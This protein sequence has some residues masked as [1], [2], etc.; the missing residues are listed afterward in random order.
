MSSAAPADAAATFAAALES[1]AYFEDPA[2]AWTAAR[3]AGAMVKLPFG[4]GVW[5]CTTWAGCAALARDPRVSSARARH[6]ESQLPLEATEVR[7]FIDLA[8]R[9]VLYLDPPRHTPVRKRLNRAFTPEVIGRNRARIAAIFEELL[10]EWIA[11]GSDEIMESLIQPFP[12]LA[13]AGWMGLPR[14]AWPRLLAWADALLYVGGSDR[15]GDAHPDSVRNWL[16][17]VEE[18]RAWLESVVASRRAGGDDLFGLLMER[19]EGEPLDRDE[20]VAQALI[21]LIAG[22]D[23]T[24]NLIGSG[25]HWMLSHGRS[26]LEFAGDDL[27]QRLA[28]DEILRITS[29]VA[30]M[31]RLAAEDFTFTG[32]TLRKGEYFLLGWASAN[33][34]PGQF[35][36]PDRMDSR[37]LNNPHLAFG[38]GPHAC[39]GLHLARTEAQIA[40]ERLFRRLPNLRLGA[41]PP[42][43]K[44]DPFS[45][46][47]ARL[48]V[49]YDGRHARPAKPAPLDGHGH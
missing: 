36:D 41:S 18:S 12:T 6:L 20:W 26:Y 21:I 11:S 10:D 28:V 13:M 5:A 1:G 42:E 30:M 47:P 8:S 33:R 46:G 14:V 44:R 29:P 34:D 45:H 3:Q 31:G 37:R 19:E 43:W 2:P 40:F 24:R 49:D 35:P 32:A 15:I 7:P 9:M 23:T 25:L 4:S 38:A 39:L 27:A 22:H 48:H 17:M 16:A